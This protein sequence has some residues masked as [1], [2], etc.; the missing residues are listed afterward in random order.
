MNLIDISNYLLVLGHGNSKIKTV[1]HGDYEEILEIESTAIE[2]PLHWVETPE[3]G[4]SGDEDH[5]QEQFNCAI[6]IAIAADP[7]DKNQRIIAE[8][9]SHELILDTVKKLIQDH[10]SGKFT[11]LDIRS[12]RADPV[13]VN[14]DNGVGWRLEVPVR[15]SL[16]ALESSIIDI[17]YPSFH[18]DPISKSVIENDNTTLDAYERYYKIFKDGNEEI[19][20][21]PGDVPIGENYEQIYIE[22][23][24]VGKHHELV[25]S[26]Y[27]D[28][29]GAEHHSLPYSNNPF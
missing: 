29:P 15:C 22:L 7:K 12:F 2:Y 19:Y 25:A 3:I 21:A 24:Y 13:Q 4:F 20:E 18:F 28:D 11:N 16:G 6:V 17:Q 26:M 14:T 8:S 23:K 10:R 27:F 1:S 9:D 5:I